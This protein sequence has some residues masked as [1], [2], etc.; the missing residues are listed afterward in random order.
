M[1]GI[2]HYRT[3]W[4]GWSLLWERD[5]TRH[6]G[7]E[8]GC[9]VSSLP[10]DRVQEGALLSGDAL[11][12][13]LLLLELQQPGILAVITPPLRLTKAQMTELI[14]SVALLQP[15]PQRPKL[16]WRLLQIIDRG[17]QVGHWRLPLPMIP[18]ELP[19][20]ASLWNTA[21]FQAGLP[22]VQL[23]SI[24]RSHLERAQPDDRE[25]ACGQLILLALCY[26]GIL[27]PSMLVALPQVAP[28]LPQQPLTFVLDPTTG[29]VRHHFASELLQTALESFNRRYRDRL[30]P[31]PKGGS[32]QQR[33][34][35]RWLTAYGRWAQLPDSL[36]PLLTHPT[37][38][39]EAAKGRLATRLPAWLVAYA[40][41]E[42][43]T[44]SL[45]SP[46]MQRI[47][48]PNPGVP[49]LPPLPPLPLT[50]P[51][52]GLFASERSDAAE[53]EVYLAL[54]D[55]LLQ[56][57]HP[58]KT[59]RA[60]TVQQRIQSQLDRDAFRTLP[61]V[62]LLAEWSVA[63]LD[64]LRASS[65][66]TVLTT[67]G[68]PLVSQLGLTDLRTDYS[69]A[70]F[71]ELY[72]QLLDRHE[73]H[74]ATYQ[75][76][77]L[78]LQGFHAWLVQ[79]YPDLPTLAESEL[80]TCSKRIFSVRAT[81]LTMT[82][83]QQVRDLI[84]VSL[85]SPEDQA[86][87]TALFELAIRT[88]LRRSEIL[89]LT[90]ESF[91]T[92]TLD[93]EPNTYTLLKTENSRRRLPQ[94]LLQGAKAVRQR[95]Q[96]TRQE[97]A[98][99]LFEPLVQHPAHADRLFRQLTQWMQ[100]VSQD[101]EVHSHSNRHTFA[102]R[103]A[104]LLFHHYAL[105]TVQQRLQQLL[106]GIALK[107]P[108]SAE[109]MKSLGTEHHTACQLHLL[110]RLL[111]HGSAQVT[112]RHYL[113]I[114]DMLYG[115]AIAVLQ[116]EL[117]QPQRAGLAGVS[118][119]TLQRRHRVAPQR[120]LVT[121][122]SHSPGRTSAPPPSPAPSRPQ[123]PLYRPPQTRTEQI[124]LIGHLLFLMQR[125]QDPTRLSQ[126]YP[127][128][129]AQLAEWAEQVAAQAPLFGY[130][131]PAALQ[132][133]WRQ[134]PFRRRRWVMQWLAQFSPAEEPRLAHLVTTLP[135][136]LQPHRHSLMLHCT[137]P[138]EALAWLR[139][140]TD[141]HFPPET[142][143]R[144]WFP[145]PKPSPYSAILTPHQQRQRWQKLEP[146]T[147]ATR[148]R[149]QPAHSSAGSLQFKITEGGAA[150]RYTLLLLALTFKKESS[151]ST[152]PPFSS[153][154]CSRSTTGC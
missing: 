107:L 131:D 2:E 57:F 130:T 9:A 48:K 14:Q 16:R 108:P 102:N 17:N 54:Y 85:L 121:S 37:A 137:R 120:P 83:Q 8:E 141:G 39:L 138:R 53:G 41:D 50:G 92:A 60:A 77:Q 56:A 5:S 87:L 123:R 116:P 46:S 144:H 104:L 75:K 81:L 103:I 62:Q 26:D 146:L 105:P 149:S 111:G 44:T 82:E 40:S 118:V 80:F 52:H 36:Q 34:L 6:F 119:R 45:P 136:V 66:Y 69:E 154:P 79:H 73:T 70:D 25:I 11:V 95:L 38:L 67:L 42:T 21:S 139:Q 124:V 29:S 86:L 89:T 150:L 133:G 32:A 49:L 148:S 125:G 128:T 90:V 4:I 135:S 63:Q 97:Q 22:L 33:Q 127:V 68:R 98:T 72:S 115:A 30:E 100:Q 24:V 28:P 58:L 55:T 113:H 91:R 153:A 117:T 126:R 109:W 94:D 132:H 110:A 151:C 114:L 142:I 43:L 10:L 112:L 145:R 96:Q 61:S 13:S 15:P 1:N 59:T 152:V 20:P 74:P 147:E 78:I 19:Q 76:L 23:E 93:V 65:Q 12:K 31:I 106:G 64:R 27:L 88:G 84:A 47:L 3:L 18:L 143:Q 51:P 71:M 35:K 101:P 7:A 122:E 129:P 140:L 99:Y 134:F